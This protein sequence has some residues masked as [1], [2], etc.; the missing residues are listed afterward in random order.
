MSDTTLLRTKAL[1]VI[2]ADDEPLARERMR[3]LLQDI[4][5]ENPTELVGFATTG[6]EILRMAGTADV[7]AIISDIRMPAMDGIE[8]AR[9]LSTIHPKPAL[10]FA[11]A[12]ESHALAAFD[13]DAAD[14]LLKPV[15]RERLSQAL[16][17]VRLLQAPS[18][19]RPDHKH[20][21]I[22]TSCR[23]LFIPLDEIL[24]FRAEQKYVTVRTM[25]REHIHDAALTDLEHQHRV[26]FIRIHR[27]CLVARKAIHGVERKRGQLFVIVKGIH[28]RLPVSRRMASHLRDIL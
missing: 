27:N 25:E 20:V 19:G 4:Q 16:D 22:K 10:I 14:Y 8:M 7:D 1:R 23:S 3:N 9:H 26:R 11:T 6:A 2:I 28:E 13:V 15:R 24:Y 12:H 18:D 21:V 17:R 5:S